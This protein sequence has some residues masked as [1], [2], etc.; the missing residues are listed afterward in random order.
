M[1][2]HCKTHKLKP[3]GRKRIKDTKK[4]KKTYGTQ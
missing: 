4:V 3:E 2:G 1:L